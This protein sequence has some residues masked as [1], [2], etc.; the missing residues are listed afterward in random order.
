MTMPSGK[1]YIGDLCYV[2]TD[3]E[4]DQFCDITIKNDR[5]L[6]GEF[7]M[8]DGRRFATYGTAYGDGCYKDQYGREYCVDAGLIGCI[9]VEDIRAEK[10]ENIESLGSIVEFDYDFSTSGGRNDQGRDWDGV[11]RIGTVLI[12]TDPQYE[13]EEY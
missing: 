4:W 3:K 1:Y 6:E 12:E 7:N 5:C 10:Y 11:I 8:P 9:R 13:E 2:M